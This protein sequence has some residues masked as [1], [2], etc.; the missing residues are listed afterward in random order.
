MS[1]KAKLNCSDKIVLILILL[2]IK[3]IRTENQLV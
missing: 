2:M 1:E 3:L